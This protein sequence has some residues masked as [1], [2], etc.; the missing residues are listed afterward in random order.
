MSIRVGFFSF[1]NYLDRT[2]FSGALYYMYKALQKQDVEIINL[3]NP[4][5]PSP[6]L[7]ITKV[8]NL[9]IKNGIIKSEKITDD[10]YGSFINIVH[11]Q[12]KI[13]NCD[14]IFAP[15]ATKE[16]SFLNTNLP[17]LFLSDTTPKLIKN[18]YQTYKNEKEYSLACKQELMVISKAQ[19]LIYTSQWAANSAIYDFNA[20]PDNVEIVS[21]GANLEFVPPII[22][23]Y[24]KLNYQK[25]RLLFIGG[26]WERKGGDIVL[27]TFYSLI[28]S[29]ID[30]ELVIVG[31]MPTNALNNPKIT[32]IPFLNKNKPSEYKKYI[33]LLRE[34]H[35]LISPTRADCS[36]LVF[37]EANAYGVPAITTNI[38][39]ISDLIKEGINGYTLSLSASGNE[40]AKLIA[41][42][43]NNQR[44]YK[45]LVESSRKEYETRL[46]WE[47]WAEQMYL[48]MTDTLKYLSEL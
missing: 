12:L 45:L 32:T 4:Q 6:L 40:Y 34:S 22:D 21:L 42:I 27:E 25:C 28:D 43:F 38:G 30:T 41:D 47:R 35:F 46:N 16:L 8:K 23:I 5:K 19:K 37:S 31:A 14:L 24:E 3:G 48:I 7:N 13:N 33:K 11:K 17:I 36:P 26:N 39:G 2:S 10:S 1:K 20:D 29:G 18:S 15:L 9:F 44:A